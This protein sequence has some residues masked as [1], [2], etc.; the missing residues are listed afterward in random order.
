MKKQHLIILTFILSLVLAACGCK[1]EW[2]DATCSS[3]KT[4][5]LCGATEGTIGIHIWQEATC[6]SPKHC[7]LCQLTEGDVIAHNWIEPTCTTAKTCFNCNVTEGAPLGHTWVDATCTTAKIC[8]S[9]G[10]EDGTP[11][12]HILTSSELIKAPTCEEV[13]QESGTCT[14]CA[15]VLT[16]D[17]PV[18]DHTPGEWKITTEATYD[19]AGE[20]AQECTACSTVLEVESYDLTAEEKE[21]WYK[22]NCESLKYTDIARNP[23]DYIGRRVKITGE[24]FIVIEEPEDPDYPSVYLVFTKKEYGFYS[25]N[26]IFALV[27]NPDVRILEGDVITFYGELDGLYDDWG[28]KHPKLNVVFYDIK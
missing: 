6:S 20:R 19:T 18:L 22:N 21:A 17:I 9:C 14:R 13:G 25:G 11:L 7:T 5:T 2:N 24:V 4:C 26:Q 28:E 8:S 10:Y 16:Q 1:H 27:T 3:P 23:D 15:Q 12:G